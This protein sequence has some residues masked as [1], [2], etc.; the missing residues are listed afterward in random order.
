MADSPTHKLGQLIGEYYE[1]AVVSLCKPVAN[2]V[3]MYFD[4][5]HSR[6]ARKN[7]KN[8]KWTDI[9]GNNHD[10]DIVIES[11]GSE[12]II[13]TP[14]A[15]IEVG[16]RRY[17][18]H[19][20]NKAQEISGALV[21]IANKYHLSSPFLGAALAGD[22]TDT[23][24]SQLKSE[25]FHVMHFTYCDFV[26]AFLSKGVDIRTDEHSSDAYVEEVVP[27]VE[28]LSLDDRN[29]IF[30]YLFDKHREKVEEFSNSLYSSLTRT[31][32][33]VNIC[34]FDGKEYEYCSV[35]DAISSMENDKKSQISLPK[36]LYQTK[37]IFSDGSSVEDLHDSINQT[38]DILQKIDSLNM[39]K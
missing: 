25:G 22:F 6:S 2:S 37:V 12:K 4:Y 28:G 24:I 18:K 19:S 34:E 32:E 31:I 39:I 11:G 26:E 29:Q 38:I 21:P 7:G 23:S 5:C 35:Q 10:L 9:H 36:K 8:V 30:N 20:K 33:T 16:W 17:T 27:K 15:F 14:R 3:G 1:Y 13:G